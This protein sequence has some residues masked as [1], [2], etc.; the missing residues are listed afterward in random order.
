MDPMITPLFATTI[1]IG[2]GVGLLLLIVI[3]VLLFR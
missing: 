1:W 3:L 2:S